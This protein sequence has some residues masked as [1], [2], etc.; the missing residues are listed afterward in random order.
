MNKKGNL[1]PAIRIYQDLCRK[2]DNYQFLRSAALRK[3]FSHVSS[4][5]SQVSHV[6]FSPSKYRGDKN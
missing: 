6:F 1:G 4:R 2:N 5:F 3:R